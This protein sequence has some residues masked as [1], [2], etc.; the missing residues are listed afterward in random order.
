MCDIVFSGLEQVVRTH[1]EVTTK[2]VQGRDF[3]VSRYGVPSSE[4][5]RY[6]KFFVYY[7]LC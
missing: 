3:Q 1:V 4:K 2:L 6:R 7:D 5:T